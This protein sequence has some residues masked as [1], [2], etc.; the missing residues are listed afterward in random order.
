MSRDGNGL[1]LDWMLE[2]SN[3]NLITFLDPKIHS[4]A[5]PAVQSEPPI[6]ISFHCNNFVLCVSIQ[7]NIQTFNTELRDSKNEEN[8]D[9][10]Q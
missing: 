3:P 4:E 5:D 7:T 8:D 10:V 9:N 1:D 2:H 6:L